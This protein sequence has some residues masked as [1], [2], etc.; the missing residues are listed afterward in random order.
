VLTLLNDD[1][2]LIKEVA[3][4]LQTGQQQMRDM[5]ACVK[6]V[7]HLQQVSRLSKVKKQAYDGC[8]SCSLFERN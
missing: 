2:A 3:E 8:Q 7:G 4:N 6:M 1:E 5:L